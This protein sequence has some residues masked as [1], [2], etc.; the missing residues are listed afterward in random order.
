[1]IWDMALDP[2]K[3]CF[4][5]VLAV[6]S[7]D[8]DSYSAVVLHPCAGIHRIVEAQLR[9]VALAMFPGTQVGGS[10]DVTSVFPKAKQAKKQ[11]SW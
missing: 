2:S 7:W 1:M 10:E 11:R 6:G 8:R 5:T 9:V 4:E 3:G